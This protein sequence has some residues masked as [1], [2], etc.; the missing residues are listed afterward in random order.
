MSSGSTTE[1]INRYQQGAISRRG[2]AQAAAALGVSAAT[3]GALIRAAA[4]QTPEASPAASPAASPVSSGEVITNSLTREEY[5]ALLKETF[6]FE[7]PQNSG[8]DI[9]YQES[10]DIGTLNPVLVQD[11]YAALIAGLIFEPLIGTSIVDGIEVPSGLADGWEISPDGLEYTIFLNPN[12]TW[13][14][15]TPFTSADVVFTFDGALAENSQS[16][17]KTT[18]E[19]VLDR[20][21]AVDDHTVKFYAKAPSGIFL[22]EALAQFE[23]IAKHIWEGVDPID[24]PSDGGSTGIEPERVVGTGPFKFQEW[25]LGEV[26]TLVSN[27]NY[28][29]PD[30]VPVVDTFIY[31]VVGDANSILANLQTGAAD[32]TGVGFADANVVKDSNPEL[33]IVAVDSLAM[34]YYYFNQDPAKTELF[35]D[36]RVRQALQYALDRDLLADM[37]YFGYAV[38]ADGTQPVLSI[39]YDPSKVNTIYTYDPEKANALLEEA[40]WVD[41]DGDGVRE[42]DGQKLTFDMIYSEG[43]STYPVM[44]PYMQDAWAQVGVEAIT[45]AIPFQSLLDQTDAGD[46]QAS[47]AGFGWSIDGGQDAMFASW[48]TPPAGFNNMRYSNADYDALVEPSKTE[49]DP[50]KRIEILH[51]QSNILNDDA[52]VGI[53][54]FRQNL[55]GGAARLHNFFPVGYSGFWW[56]TRAWV[57]A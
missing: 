11:T 36:P 18:V 22:T 52:A 14:D 21:E 39:A 35:T 8:G 50:E 2:F 7:E 16:V 1:L 17:R 20:Y 24:W 38:R 33:Q 25:K 57:D 26:I 3:A 5:N 44:I 30:D 27:E 28:W 31:Q 45:S 29:Q 46:F 10:T 53:N 49:V 12:V 51:E 23:I 34:N 47:V 32:V 6:A 54:V 13:H 37:V 40:G 42:K 48:N 56:L 41:S 55:Y 4:A 15:G 9:I 19:S 43:T